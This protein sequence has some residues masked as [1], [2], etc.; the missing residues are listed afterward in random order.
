M[1]FH[2]SQLCHVV[3]LGRCRH[4]LQLRIAQIVFRST[5]KRRESYLADTPAAIATRISWTSPA[6]SLARPFRSPR[7]QRPSSTLSRTFSRRT[8]PAR[9]LRHTSITDALEDAGGNVVEVMDHSDHA[10]PRTLMKY[11]DNGNK[12]GSR[13]AARL[14]AK[15]D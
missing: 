2:S 6:E 11:N 4:V 14:S 9:G 15:L 5:W 8:R 7:A 10:D 13:I 3:S 1:R 12:A